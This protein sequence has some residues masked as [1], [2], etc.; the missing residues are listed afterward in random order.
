MSAAD[1]SFYLFQSYKVE[2]LSHHESE[3]EMCRFLFPF[4][5]NIYNYIFGIEKSNWL[6]SSGGC[7]TSLE[8]QND[9]DRLVSHRSPIPLQTRKNS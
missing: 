7:G 9:L 8:P 1:V 3:Y 6:Q 2:M 5:L 4:F